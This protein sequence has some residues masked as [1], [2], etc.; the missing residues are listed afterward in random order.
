MMALETDRCQRMERLRKRQMQDMLLF[1]QEL[2]IRES[3][4]GTLILGLWTK[5]V[6]HMGPAPPP[7]PQVSTKPIYF[8]PHYYV[9]EP[10]SPRSSSAQHQ[11]STS[12][13]CKSSPEKPPRPVQVDVSL[14]SIFNR[15]LSLKRK[16]SLELEPE[17]NVKK[18]HL[19]IESGKTSTDF[20]STGDTRAPSLIEEKEVLCRKP[21]GRGR[22]GRRGCSARGRRGSFSKSDALE[23]GLVEIPITQSADAGE[24]FRDPVGL[25]G[26]LALWLEDGVDIDVRFKSKNVFKCIVTWPTIPTRWLCTFIYAPPNRQQRVMF[27]NSL[28]RIHEEN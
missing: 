11:V 19:L 26:G 2:N 14:S 7:P 23:L 1:C 22:A 25:S 13:L 5:P 12:A 28:R 3:C 6:T 27:W 20:G 8:P 18:P 10:D 16:T 17:V 4:P 24:F 21:R 15:L 9:E